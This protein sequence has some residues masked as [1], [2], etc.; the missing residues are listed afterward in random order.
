MARMI[1]TMTVSMRTL[2]SHAQV[3]PHPH[4]LPVPHQLRHQRRHRLQHL[5]PA[6]K[7]HL[8]QTPTAA[9][10]TSPTRMSIAAYATRPTTHVRRDV[11]GLNTC[12]AVTT[13]SGPVAHLLRHPRHLRIR[14]APRLDG[15]ATA[16]RERSRMGMAGV[17]L[18]KAVGV[19]R[20]WRSPRINTS[21]QTS[22]TQAAVTTG[23]VCSVTRVAANGMSLNALAIPRL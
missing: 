1:V 5:L 20:R 4:P 3:S 7:A 16:R 17:V 15:M 18:P 6:R 23:N 13:L 8:I 2:H 14:T 10:R 11:F 22:A 19:M 21:L 12:A 9:V